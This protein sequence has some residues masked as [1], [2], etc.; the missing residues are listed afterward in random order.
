MY[1]IAYQAND[2]NTSWFWESVE[3]VFKPE[4]LL[5]TSKASIS[6]NEMEIATFREVIMQ[7]K[8][9]RKLAKK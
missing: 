2:S 1:L 4:V 8:S 5:K 3:V 6:P 9:P 7:L